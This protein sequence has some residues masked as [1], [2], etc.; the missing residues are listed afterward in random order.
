MYRSAAQQRTC[1]SDEDLQN[2]SINSTFTF[3]T[4]INSNPLLILLGSASRLSA[5]NSHHNKQV[6]CSYL[7]QPS[8]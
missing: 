7:N 4:V 6:K 5:P 1:T 2:N 8:G 3:A